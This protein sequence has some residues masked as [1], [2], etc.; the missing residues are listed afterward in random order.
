MIPTHDCDAAA[1]NGVAIFLGL[2]NNKITTLFPCFSIG[3]MVHPNTQP[4]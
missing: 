2:C 4:I 3:L 1:I